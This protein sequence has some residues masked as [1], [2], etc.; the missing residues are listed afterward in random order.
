MKKIIVWLTVVLF[1]LSAFKYAD[2]RESEI[3]KAVYPRRMDITDV[4][5]VNGTVRENNRKDV[6][7]E[8]TFIMVKIF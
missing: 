8:A 5:T 2:S 7:S 6:Y 3:Y 1:V 4:L